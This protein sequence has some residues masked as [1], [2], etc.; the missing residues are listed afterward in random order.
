MHID[1]C[2]DFKEH[3]EHTVGNGIKADR[4]S[5]Q[6][7]SKHE[8]RHVS[9]IHSSSI[10]WSGRTPD[11]VGFPRVVQP[12]VRGR[13]KVEWSSGCG[14]GAQ[15]QRLACKAVASGLRSTPTGA[16]L[17]YHTNVLPSHLRLSLVAYKL[18]A[19]LYTFPP[20]HPCFKT[21]RRCNV[22]PLPPL[23]DAPP[24][25]C[26]LRLPG[27]MECIDPIPIQKAD[28]IGFDIVPD[29]DQ[30]EVG[31]TPRSNRLIFPDLIRATAWSQTYENALHGG[32]PPSSMP[33][34]RRSPYSPWSGLGRRD[35]AK[36]TKITILIDSGQTKS[37][38]YVP[39][40][41]LPL[42]G[43]T[44]SVQEKIPTHPLPIGTRPHC[45][46]QWRNSRCG[47][48]TSCPRTPSPL[49]ARIALCSPARSHVASCSD[50]D[51]S[52]RI[53]VQWTELWLTSPKGSFTK[54]FDR[55][56]PSPKI[57]RIFENMSRAEAS[58]FTQLCTGHILFHTYSFCS[59]AAPSPDCP[60]CNVPETVGT[61]P[62]SLWALF[63]WE[64]SPPS[65][66]ESG[67]SPT[68]TPSINHISAYLCHPRV[69]AAH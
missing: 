27:R 49:F 17:H 69:R 63:R 44:S 31:K 51:F 16:L 35:T 47:S 19:R 7:V 62:S 25:Q 56:A 3:I 22:N 46:H 59:W 57:Q 4:S 65:S 32:S 8:D 43:A 29:K 14:C 54:C 50:M 9:Q 40:R 26:P 13:R 33:R 61:F 39:G 58:M 66:D 67:Q 18:A 1:R 68:Q 55:S 23:T 15:A 5:T 45:H 60:Y 28:S 48:Q 24:S 21:I 64:T 12:G 2:L 20:A 52:K 34:F 36:P 38:A 30:A 10:H 41:R 42:S 11:R 53:Q 6:T 37:G